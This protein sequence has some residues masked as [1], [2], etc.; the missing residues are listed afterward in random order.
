MREGYTVLDYFS[1]IGGMQSLIFS[2]LAVLISLW[3]HNYMDDY[4]VSKLY[5]L[6]AQNEGTKLVELR[7]HILDNP[8]SFCRDMLSFCICKDKCCK[9]DRR[10][11]AFAI[12]REKLKKE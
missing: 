8:R 1:D 4:M 3:N 10:R 5:K 9:E 11:R 6:K 12:A 2:L 7:P